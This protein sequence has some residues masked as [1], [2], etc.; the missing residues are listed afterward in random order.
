MVLPSRIVTLVVDDPRGTLPTFEVESPWWMESG[1][2]VEAARLAFGVDVTIV[3]LLE[4]EAFPGGRVTYLVEAPG[5]DASL[6]ARWQGELAEDAHRA[7]YA[8][9]GGIAALAEWADEALAEQGL[10]R[11]GPVEQVRT[12]NL[13]CLL[14]M[15]TTDGAVLWLKAV[16]DF[17]A[18]EPEVMSALAGVDNT[19]VP[20]LLAS[21]RGVTLMREVGECDGYEVTPERHL[22]AVER[23]HVARRQLDLGGLAT[24]PWFGPQQ[25]A[26]ELLALAEC[27][28]AEL[29]ADE[30]ARLA[31][32]SDQVVDRWRA[33]G[34]EATLVHGDLHGGNLRLAD[35]YPDAIIDWGD[36][37]ITHPLF[38]LAVLDS[39]TPQ[40]GSD[41]TDRW[42][43][44]IGSEP[45]AWAAFRPLA[46]I[47]LAI[48]YQRFCN[49]I[50]ASE[51]IYHRNDIVPAIRTGLRFFVE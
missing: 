13:S 48:V 28:Q 36:A 16:P 14:R 18:H 44:T 31:A 22:E 51:Q 47:R 5:V 32:L 15:R 17:F 34:D 9:T 45:A 46:A 42:L 26:N 25:M 30:N 11:R 20:G 40:W 8:E 49:S 39:Y 38:D 50:E 41:T 6:L 1:P 24:V 3:R 19:L 23:F 7:A 4:G 10:Q 43:E 35:E 29:S 33:A 12:W 37:S 27:H 2:L 21:R